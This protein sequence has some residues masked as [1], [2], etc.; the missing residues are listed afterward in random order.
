MGETRD[1]QPS[2][3]K[4]NDVLVT[5]DPWGPQTEWTVILGAAGKVEGSDLE[6]VWRELVE[7]YREPVMRAVKRQLHYSPEAEGIANEF[8]AYLF[9]RNVLPKIDPDQ[10]RFRCYI[11]Q[12]LRRYVLHANRTMSP[13]KGVASLDDLDFDGEADATDDGAEGREED[14]WASAVLANAIARLEKEQERNARLLLSAYG[15]P[16]HEKIDRKELREAEG[17]TKQALDVAIFRARR[18]LGRL[19]IDEVRGTVASE[20]DFESE[21]DMIKDRLLA[22]HPALLEASDDEGGD[23]S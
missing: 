2:S 14:E 16:P 9:E 21:L 3:G 12:V 6:G 11:Q 17:L 18:E 1:K 13:G 20:E 22:S 4:S 23:A 10:G 5:S 7:R 19:I 8:F 15:I